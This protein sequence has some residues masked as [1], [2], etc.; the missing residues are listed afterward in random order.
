MQT[1]KIIL[2]ESGRVANLKK[3]FPLYVG[4]YQN[5]LLNVL[6]PK[7][8]LAPNFTSHYIDTDG[9]IKSVDGAYT[10]VKIGMTY[11]ERTGVIKQS[12][13]FFMRYLKDVI[14]NNVEYSMYERL[15]PKEF[16]LFE[17]Q[18]ENAP[19]LIVNIVNVLVSN[20]EAQTLELIT[21]QYASID[22]MYS[23]EL[24]N[25]PEYNPTDM[26][27]LSAEVNSIINELPNKI[28]N[29]IALKTIDVN[30]NSF[31][32][33]DKDGYKEMGVLFFNVKY[34]IKSLTQ[35]IEEEKSGSVIV[36]DVSRVGGLKGQ[37]EVFFFN[38]GIA[39]RLITMHPFN[40]LIGEVGDWEIISE[41]DILA[42]YDIAKTALE[43]LNSL[44]E[45]FK[46]V[47]QTAED[48]ERLAK[49]A[50]DN[51]V[52]GSGTKVVVGGQSVGTLSF[53]TDPQ[54]QIDGIN[55]NISNL[56]NNKANKNEIESLKT[57]VT[58]N[59]NDISKKADKS[60]TDSLQE[61]VSVNFEEILTL[62]EHKAEKYDVSLNS[63]KITQL[64]N[65][66][67]MLS[68]PNL[69][70]NGDFKV[71]QRGL[72]NYIANTNMDIVDKWKIQSEGSFDVSTNTFTSNTRFSAIRQEVK[73]FDAFRGKTLTY[74]IYVN[75]VEENTFGVNV[76]DG[77]STY[78]KG[79]LTQGLNTFTVT[80]DENATQ[81]IFDIQN[82]VAG[83]HSIQ[84]EYAKVELGSI[85][86]PFSPKPYE[87][88]LVNCQVVEGGLATT[89]SNPN[90]LINGDF[91]VNQRGETSYTG[92]KYT[93]DRWQSAG[94]N[95]TVTPTE[96]GVKIS[97]T[98]GGKYYS[99]IRQKIEM[100]LLQYLNKKITVS[101]L[102]RSL[103]GNGSVV[104]RV[105]LFSDSNY[106]TRVGNANVFL[107]NTGISSATT[108]IPETARYIMVDIYKGTEYAKEFEIDYIKLELGSIATAF[109]PRPYAEELALC[110]RYYRRIN[111]TKVSDKLIGL[112]ISN[113]SVGFL[114][115]VFDIH[116]RT[117][118]TLHHNG[119]SIYNGVS[120]G[121][122][123][124][125]SITVGLVAEPINNFNL[126]INFTGEV[127]K[128]YMLRINKGAGNYIEFD[129]EIY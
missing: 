45:E 20:E 27:L 82:R 124:I 15:L 19:K 108:I 48:A 64:T 11:L 109:S 33:F 79:G 58:T 120:G 106:S 43:H 51:V 14:V 22:V 59:T 46:T 69:L 5:K 50:L 116:M 40:N 105:Q 65:Q 125:S 61:Q 72:N 8:I 100:N 102:V 12:T 123:N 73:N 101:T 107:N 3:D 80:I 127:A 114:P 32:A 75:N 55:L 39:Q 16:T 42:S 17:G 31:Y 29:S 10:A 98:E 25:E 117:S 67:K 118:P 76:R 28:D 4:S 111:S 91:R 34:N 119:L 63:T 122:I 70:L 84:L 77:V 128:I 36:V 68:N 88:E 89:Y 38:G 53:N 85:A 78:L 103:S 66:V 56:E 24:N 35:D 126:Q 93:V 23:A 49:E 115:Y 2:A 47:R 104:L 52:E 6:V 26:A 86:T 18:G 62:Q 94:G 87:E 112:C 1:I 9:V 92:S 71:N 90:L 30:N 99:L 121:N 7:S 41:Q 60:I 57:Q 110:Q 21:S 95:V 13:T 113:G 81:L 83:T 54:T 129:A 37:T 44:V 97:V 96:N 74:S